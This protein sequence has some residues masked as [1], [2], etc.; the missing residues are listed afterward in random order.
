[1]NIFYLI[2]LVITSAVFIILSPFLFLYAVAGKRLPKGLNE[3]LGWV[4]S[5][6][7]EHPAGTPHIWIHAASLG[8]V[9]V[10]ETI[11][12]EL[13]RLV[14]GSSITV[15]T[16]TEHGKRLASEILGKDIR[17]IYS[18]LDIIFFVR[19][20]VKRVR[21]EVLVFLETEIWPA[22]ISEASRMGVRPVIVNGRISPGSFSRYMRIRPLFRYVLSR[23]EALSMIS[24]KDKDRITAMGAD[25]AKVGVNGN[26]KFDLLTELADP[27][28]ENEIRDAFSLDEQ[29]LVFI[30]GSTRNGEEEI[31]IEAYRNI[32][33]EFPETI[34]FIAPRHIKRSKYIASLLER[35]GL[36][37]Q[38]RSE[39]NRGSGK[40]ERQVVILDTFGELFRLYSAG[41]VIFSGGSMVP[42]GGQNPLEAAVW[43]KPVLYGPS[44]E[45]FL[46]AKALLEGNA[47]GIEVSTPEMLAEKVIMLFKDRTLHEGYGSRARDAV[48]KNSKAARKHARVIADIL[49]RTH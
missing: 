34:L 28:I 8:E 48:L 33:R 38:F 12:G 32:I 18:P 2:Y 25:P 24:E 17:V 22:W 49:N 4:S 37:Y 36:E 23:V 21:P 29:A 9:R 5:N 15:S 3:R 30:A 10:A 43:G 16:M 40:R 1:M 13:K 44:M 42:L 46:D 39:F 26:A 19:M 27:S 7:E 11:V 6:G 31:I 35:N 41:T 20:A 45:H 47:A 14:P